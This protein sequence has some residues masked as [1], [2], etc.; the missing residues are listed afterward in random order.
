MP[1]QRQQI[2][3]PLVQRHGSLLSTG[4]P[5][6]DPSQPKGRLSTTPALLLLAQPGQGSLPSPPQRSQVPSVKA[7]EPEDARAATA[8]LAAGSRGPLRAEGRLMRVG[9][10]MEAMD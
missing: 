8:R 10:V 5:K 2:T 4:R 6:A 3:S 7:D 9:V 1:L